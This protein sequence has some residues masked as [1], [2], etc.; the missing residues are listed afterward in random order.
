MDEAALHFQEIIRV[1]CVQKVTE[2]QNIIAGHLN[3][4]RNS[5]YTLNETIA[6]RSGSKNLF[7]IKFVL[8]GY[9]QYCME[10]FCWLLWSSISPNKPKREEMLAQAVV[11][12]LPYENTVLWKGV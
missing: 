5:I 12:K 7:R 10:Y 3:R 4:R 2:A 8:D 1:K 9:V 11:E 6:I